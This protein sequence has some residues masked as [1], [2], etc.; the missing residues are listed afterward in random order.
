MKKIVLTALLIFGAEQALAK[1]Y[2]FVN[3]NGPTQVGLVNLQHNG[4][5]YKA[6]KV[7]TQH[8]NGF[9]GPHDAIS[10]ND[11]EGDL[12]LV[13]AKK[14]TG[15]CGPNRDCFRFEGYS[16]Q[17]MG[18]NLTPTEAQSIIVTIDADYK[19]NLGLKS[20]TLT[21]HRTNKRYLIME[22]GSTRY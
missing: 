4:Q 17:A 16:G 6:T 3:Q 9:A 10:F 8:I 12:L 19:S 11:S 1:C 14:F 21:D 18:R 13:A 5:V 2:N 20:G 15:R 7:C 22:A